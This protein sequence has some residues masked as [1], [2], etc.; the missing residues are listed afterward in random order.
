MNSCV[1]LALLVSAPAMAV[2]DNPLSTVFDLMASLEAKIIKEGE[3]EAKA[4]KEYY[5][6]CDEASQN[7]N[8]EIKTDKT[9]IE[10][11]N[12]KIGELSSDIDVSDSKI[13]ELANSISSNEAELKA[14]TE[15]REKEAADFAVSE[16][17]LVDTVDTPERLHQAGH[18]GSIDLSQ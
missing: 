16:K 17:E 14:A 11:L 6:W 3:A 18:A 7:L 9:S 2:Q 13:G 4:Y 10:K 12:A 15:I 1:L 5:E 8:N